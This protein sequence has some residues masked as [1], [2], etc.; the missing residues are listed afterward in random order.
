MIWGVTIG[1]LMGKPRVRGS[2]A[3]RIWKVNKSTTEFPDLF[4]M[5]QFRRLHR[6]S[7]KH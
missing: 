3:G 1:G 4:A 7:A 5:I 6:M 2:D